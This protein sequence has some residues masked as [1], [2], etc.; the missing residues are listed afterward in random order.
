[1]RIEGVVEIVP[2]HI[3]LGRPDQAIFVRRRLD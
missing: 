2:T 3:L 1:M